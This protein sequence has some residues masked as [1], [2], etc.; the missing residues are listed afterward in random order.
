MGTNLILDV[1]VIKN[2][3]FRLHGLMQCV[4]TKMYLTQDFIQIITLVVKE[5]ITSLSI[6][7]RIGEANV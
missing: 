3:V 7:W 1:E 5:K 2:L 4:I 6:L